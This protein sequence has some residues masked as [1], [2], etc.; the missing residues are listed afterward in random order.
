MPV[1]RRA[2]LSVPPADRE[3]LQL[4]L[5]E[6]GLLD[7]L[8]H[9]FAPDGDVV[10]L[11]AATEEEL[12]RLLDAARSQ[13]LDE[14]AVRRWWRPTPREL[15]ACSWL[16]MDVWVHATGYARIR[17]EQAHDDTH[18]CPV[19]GAGRRPT[20][21]VRLRRGEIPKRGLLGSVSGGILLFHEELVARF[22]E[23]AVTGM[24]WVQARD[25]EDA[26]LPWYE[27]RVTA[28]APRMLAASTG[29]LRGRIRGEAPCAACAQDGWFDDPEQPFTPAYE[30][31]ALEALPDVVRTTELFGTGQ[32]E[33]GDEPG[34]VAYPRLLVRQHVYAL[35]R[36]GK[37]R[38]VR[39]SPVTV[40]AP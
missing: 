8:V 19:C 16:V 14:P 9:P 23:E 21:P 7:Q 5:L 34:W 37:V 24:E 18:A 33:V 2:L 13:G 39:F 1:E 27:V 26:P 35:F 11:P 6:A 40:L 10:A 30:A 17:P 36:R 28:T 29:V 25:R 22:R 4:A 31:G 38:G 32:V 20:A 15:R 12:L 3:R